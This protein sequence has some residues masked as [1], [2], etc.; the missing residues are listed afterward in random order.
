VPIKVPPL[1]DRREDIPLMARHFMARSSEAARLTPREFGVGL[2]Q[3]FSFNRYSPATLHC[4]LKQCDSANRKIEL[5]NRCLTDTGLS[6]SLALC[7][8]KLMS[9]G[10]HPP[11]SDSKN[12]NSKSS[13][14]GPRFGF[15]LFPLHSQWPC[16]PTRRGW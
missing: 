9:N 11:N 10:H 14:E 15:E 13:M 5:E 2:Q 7:S 12:Y 1:R 8:N 16:L 3:I 6:P 4:T